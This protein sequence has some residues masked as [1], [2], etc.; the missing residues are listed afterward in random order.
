MQEKEGEREAG[1]VSEITVRN[2]RGCDLG[3]SGSARDVQDWE[4][5]SEIV[6]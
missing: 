1:H 6:A 3:R 4:G 5:E 2:A